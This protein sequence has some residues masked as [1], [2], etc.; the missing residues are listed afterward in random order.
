[1]GNMTQHKIAHIVAR[2]NFE[3]EK[4]NNAQRLFLLNSWIE[5]LTQF[6]EYELASALLSIKIQL[7]R[8]QACS[9]KRKRN[10]VQTIKLKIKILIRKWHT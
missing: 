7:I 1:M 8:S 6:E 9:K 3:K 4:L 10:T 5:R 2:Y